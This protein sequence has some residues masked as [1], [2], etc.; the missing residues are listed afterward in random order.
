MYCSLTFKVIHT[1][2]SYESNDSYL[3]L[4]LYLVT[5]NQELS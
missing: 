2:S 3:K 4:V 1:Y 5:L